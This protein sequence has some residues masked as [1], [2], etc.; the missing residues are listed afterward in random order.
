M[1]VEFCIVDGLGIAATA[2]PQDNSSCALI[3]SN[4][5]SIKLMGKYTKQEL[6]KAM[7][8]D[9]DKCREILKRSASTI[10]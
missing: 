6:C 1:S 3:T 9:L 5:G 7:C 8:A 2:E 10:K 4:E